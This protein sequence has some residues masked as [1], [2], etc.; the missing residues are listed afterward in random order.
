ML[1]A[2]KHSDSLLTFRI[3]PSF[4]PTPKGVGFPARKFCNQR[5]S[6]EFPPLSCM[7]LGYKVN[8]QTSGIKQQVPFRILHRLRLSRY[9]DYVSHLSCRAK[10][11]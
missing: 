4:H 5:K 3:L 9:A 8:I 6:G 11:Y 1:K 7:L 2:P 10:I